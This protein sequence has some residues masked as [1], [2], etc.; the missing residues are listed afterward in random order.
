MSWTGKGKVAIVGVGFSTIE[1]NTDRPLGR[2]ALNA[3]EEALKDAGV[4]PSQVD[5]LATYPRAPFLGATEK[6]G[7]EVVSVEY[8]INHGNFGPIR[9]YSELNEGMV[10]SAVGEAV[11]AI[12]GGM[13]NYAVVWRAM[14]HPRG[15]YGRIVKDQVS[16]VGQFFEPYGC[17]SPIQWHAL[18]FQR[19]LNRFGGMGTD[20]APLVLNSR[21]NANLNEHAYF[22]EVPLTEAEYF[23]SRVISSPL[24]LYDCD[25]PVQG[26]IAL[27]LTSTE[28]ARD[29]KSPPAYVAGMAI[30][31]VR[32]PASLHYTLSDHMEVG[33]PVASQL[34]NDSGYGP[35]DMVAAELYDGFAPST[36]YWLES[37]GFCRE[38]EALGFIKGEQIALDGLL[39]VNTHGGSLS[40][41]RLHG[42]GHLAEAVLQ[43]TERAGARQTRKRGPVCVF[44]GSPMLRGGGMVLT[45][46]L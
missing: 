12:L 25:I 18:A 9:W 24:R 27:V 8:M 35:G 20:L 38:G 14:H 29:L 1:R 2:Y 41:G 31:G 16:G 46:E 30:N 21:K 19:Y 32:Q 3:V 7:V 42:M 36:I 37:A 34:W 33:K 4:S 22:R 17:V 11:T 26:C 6:D 15:K 13:V 40:Q 43:V 5:G 23:G 10:T 39:P 45:P 28:R 44:A